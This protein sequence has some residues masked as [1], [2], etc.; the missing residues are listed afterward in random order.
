MFKWIYVEGCGFLSFAKSVGT[1]ATKIAEY[2]SNKYSQKL[3]R[4]AKISTIDAIK[5]TSKRAT[6]KTAEAT[7]DLIR[8]KISGKITSIS[9]CP[10]S[11]SKELHSKADENE[12]ERTKE[13]YTSSGKRKQIIE[14][15]RLVK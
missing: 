5:T 9:K 15:L 3:L 7:C 13:K 10:Q 2:M 8:N 4:S 6:Q 1:H 14:K 11:S 12:I